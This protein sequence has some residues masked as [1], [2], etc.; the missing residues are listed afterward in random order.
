MSTSKNILVVTTPSIE[1]IQ[2]KQYLKPVSAH[3]V[4]GVNVF[5]DLFAGFTDFFGGRS[6]AY[7]KQLISLYEEAIEQVKYAAY[8]IGANCIVGLTIDMD[9]ISGKGKS[10][11]MITAVGTA[12]VL[13]QVARE[14]VK[15]ISHTERFTNVSKERIH[16]LRTKRKI[17]ESANA[18]TLKLDDD[19]W[20]FITG[21][22][23]DE[24]FPYILSK[25]DE[26][27][28][29][30]YL[31]FEAINIFKK[32]LIAY[33]NNLPTD[34]GKKH[35]Y[36]A[37]SNKNDRFVLKICE[38][39]DELNMYDY[40][41]VLQLLRNDDFNIRKTALRIV[42]FDKEFYN[43]QDVVDLLNLKNFISDT[44]VERGTR[45][46]KKQL[47]SSKE[48]NVWVCECGN[49]NN[50]DV[51]CSSCNQDIFGFKMDDIKP[52]A[53]EESIDQ[54]IAFIS[55]LIED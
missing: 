8:E 14:K 19:N 5:N 33:I 52:N 30:E 9:E 25:F 27:L 23:V 49:T 24:V 34:I 51:S 36:D 37:F 16:I 46:S 10:M 50:L 48:R 40:D 18:G 29:N 3:I 7:Q 21:N 38:I 15:T 17:V 44:F 12:V 42:M 45:T 54:K 47:L 31:N 6:S 41:Q 11:F 55:Q 53:V 39:I 13:E 43:K 22:Q 32:Q 35:L 4:A 28:T 1:G 2:I 26:K 20:S